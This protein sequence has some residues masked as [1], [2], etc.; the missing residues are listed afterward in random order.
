MADKLYPKGLNI[1]PPRDGAPDFVRGT[2]SIEPKQ[3]LA[4]LKENQQYMSEKGYFR[5]NLLEGNKGLYTVLDTYK[6]NK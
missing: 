2:I 3:F 1:F 4:F 5:F 6:P